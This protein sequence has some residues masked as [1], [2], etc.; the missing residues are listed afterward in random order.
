MDVI[1]DVHKMR[2]DASGVQDFFW[3]L[4][5]IE[6]E[7]ARD[8]LLAGIVSTTRA[9]GDSLDDDRDLFSIYSH[10]ISYEALACYQAWSLCRRTKEAGHRLIWQDNSRLFPLLWYE[11]TPQ[12]DDSELLRTLRS[13]PKCHP[14]YLRPAVKMRRSIMWNGITFAGLRPARMQKD[15]IACH[16]TEILE[17]N[18]HA[19]DETVKY[20]LFGDWFG[21]LDP[22]SLE[23]KAKAY[24]AS[25]VVDDVKHAMIDA[26]EA[27]G[28]SLPSF[29]W[30]YLKELITTAAPLVRVHLDRVL[31]QPKRIPRRLWTGTGGYIWN[32]LLRHAVRRQGGI[33]TGHEHGTGEGHIVY[34]NTKA[35][36]DYESA[37]SFIT[38][39]ETQAHGLQVALDKRFLVPSKQ[40]L[41]QSV[42]AQSNLLRCASEDATLRRSVRPR[43]K[44]SIIM[45]VPT[46]YNGEKPRLAQHNEDMVMVD[47]QARLLGKLNKWKYPVLYKAH[48]QGSC[49]PPEHFFTELGARSITEVVQKVWDHADVLLFD[50]INTTAFSVALN[51]DRPIIFIDFG[52]DQ[53]HPEAYESIKRRCAVVKGWVDSENRLQVDW[54]VLRKEIVSPLDSSDR[55]YL[56][57]YLR[58]DS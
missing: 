26:F 51:T 33:V 20:T 39:N 14:W 58:F 36:I 19:V 23:V 8:K 45:Y 38:F 25:P 24:L 22:E 21:K 46:I 53:F 43:S 28:E 47:W 6:F 32:R 56:E 35:F 50:Y 15:I 17:H 3:P 57:T 34:F 30:D 42:K 48:P 49:R 31:A 54:G 29:I 9:H 4:M 13:G 27:G 12:T 18:A 52:Y 41:I 40:P 55:T 10:F 11:R 16:A 1:L 5:H 7:S 44:N 37:D 2:L